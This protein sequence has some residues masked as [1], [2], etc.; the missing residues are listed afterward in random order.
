MDHSLTLLVDAPSLIYRALFSTPDTVTMPDGTPINAG[1]GFLRMLARLIGD[2]DP[3]YIACAADENWRPSWRVD[4]IEGY[5]AQRAEP[6]SQQ[7]E[8]EKKLAPQVPVI[9]SL[10]AR[11][12]VNV[13][14]HPDYEAEDVIGTLAARAPGRVGI[15]SG[16]RDLFQL[17][18]DPRCYILYP[19]RGVSK[20]DVID[21][22]YIESKYGIPGRSYADYAV[23]RG[24][25]SDG[26]P[27]VRGIGDKLAASL[28]AK[29]GGLDAIIADAE[30]DGQNVSITKVRR[31]LDYVKRARRVV[32]IPTDLPIQELDLTRPRDIPQEEVREEAKAFGLE[33]SVRALIAALKGSDV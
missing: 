29:Y 9:Y 1:H 33:N 6:G 16:D 25:P 12:G 10:L 2:H 28:V 19:I 3:D 21:E 24:D 4:L 30:G 31:D 18:E 32:A 7:E 22:S 20:I 14:G 8:S 15:F 23:L 27:G 13:I 5:K 17:V 26:L 11:C